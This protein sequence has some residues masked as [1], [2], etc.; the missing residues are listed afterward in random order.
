M[1]VEYQGR[2]F[3]V[4]ET[5]DPAEPYRLVGARGGTLSLVAHATRRGLF[6]VKNAGGK[7]NG[8]FVGQL[9]DG[10]LLWLPSSGPQAPAAQ[11]IWRANRAA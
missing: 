7:L 8:G 10:A 6:Y 5:G 4:E 9:A 2:T 3:A 11:R 1:T